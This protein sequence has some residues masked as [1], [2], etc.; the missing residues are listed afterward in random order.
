MAF[1]YNWFDISAKKNFETYL[2]RFKGKPDLLF[3]EL[4][5]FEGRATVW[6]LENI[7]TAPS[8]KIVCVDTFEGSDEHK[9]MGVD[10]NNLFNNFKENT[11]QYQDKIILT[12]GRSQEVIRKEFYRPDL[13]DFIYIDA[14]HRAP[15][16][17]EDAVLSFRLLK[18]GGVMIFDDYEWKYNNDPIESPRL[19]I[20]AFLSIFAKEYKLLLKGYQVAI[21]K[22]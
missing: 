7:L 20:D 17:L 18:K 2:E 16:V 21:Q 6:M 8:S 13:F 19:A 22:L 12:Q 11:K 3:L 4:G 5:P 14:S 15:D 1:N 9:A 10:T